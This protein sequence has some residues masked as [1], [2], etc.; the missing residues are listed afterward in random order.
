MKSVKTASVRDCDWQPVFPSIIGRL[1][2][3]L[4]A[5]TI[6][7]ARSSVTSVV[8]GGKEMSCLH[9]QLGFSIVVGGPPFLVCFSF[10]VLSLV[11]WAAPTDLLMRPGRQQM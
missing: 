9:L 8:L 4:C 10:V 6:S 2:H 1:S 3:R 7:A 5:P 11:T